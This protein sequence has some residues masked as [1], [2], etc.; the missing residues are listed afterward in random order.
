MSGAETE[1][2]IVRCHRAALRH[3]PASVLTHAT[4]R[5][6]AAKMR[7]SRQFGPLHV[8]ACHSLTFLSF[9]RGSWNDRVHSFATEQVVH[10]I[11]NVPSMVDVDLRS[12]MPVGGRS[13]YYI[14]P[15]KRVRRTGMPWWAP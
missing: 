7:F 5:G 4:V 9:H 13:E 8:D 15:R 14:V 12:Y 6:G 10:C 3:R 11:M 1:Q 2:A